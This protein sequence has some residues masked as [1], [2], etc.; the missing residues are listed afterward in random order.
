MRGR[1][2]N[3]TCV[4]IS[5]MQYKVDNFEITS[6]HTIQP[7]FS[8]KMINYYGKIRDVNVLGKKW[9]YAKIFT[10]TWTEL[11]WEQKE[12]NTSPQSCWIFFIVKWT[13]IDFIFRRGIPTF[14]MRIHDRGFYCGESF[15]W[16][17]SVQNR[18]YFSSGY[19]SCV[20]NIPGPGAEPLRI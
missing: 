19:S 7:K 10:G 3:F 18:V 9:Y 17:F 2:N 20:I 4:F 11:R 6:F 12:I 5:R 16:I 14:V 13:K 8:S 15:L 1:I